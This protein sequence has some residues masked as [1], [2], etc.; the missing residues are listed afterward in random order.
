MVSLNELASSDYETHP[1]FPFA[2]VGDAVAGVIVNDPKLKP[3]RNPYGD[4]PR[5]VMPIELETNDMGTVVI[6]AE[7]HKGMS[8]AIWAAGHE[9]GVTDIVQGATLAVKRIEDDPP[10][11]P[12]Y[13]ATRAYVAKY[14]PPAPRG[15][16]VDD[17]F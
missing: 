8:R 13:K 16:N 14:T 5:E 12:G 17:I 2:E 11:K 3:A 15:I 7:K 4:T 1:T 10:F 6:W 9:A